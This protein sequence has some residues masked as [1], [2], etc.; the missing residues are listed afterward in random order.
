MKESYDKPRQ[1]VEEQR[2]HFANKD[3]YSQSFVFPSSQSC[4]GVRVRPSR[5][6]S[7][8]EFIF[9]NCIAGEN[10]YKSLDSKEIKPVNPKGNQP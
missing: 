10:S 2:H 9:S 6:L 8:K 5:R 4:V 1:C 3:P 7:T